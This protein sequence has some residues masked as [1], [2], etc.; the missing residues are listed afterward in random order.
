MP[1]DRFPGKKSATYGMHNVMCNTRHGRSQDI[2]KWGKTACN[3]SLREQFF[4]TFGHFRLVDVSV[5]GT[6]E[7]FFTWSAYRYVVVIFKHQEE[8]IPQA[9][10]SLLASVTPAEQSAVTMMSVTKWSAVCIFVELHDG[11]FFSDG[12]ISWVD[13]DHT[14]SRDNLTPESTWITRSSWTS[15]KGDIIKEKFALFNTRF[16]LSLSSTNFINQHW[17]LSG[18]AI[19]NGFSWSRPSD[20]VRISNQKMWAGFCSPRR[21]SYLRSC[22][23]TKQAVSSSVCIVERWFSQFYHWYTFISFNQVRHT[24]H[25]HSRTCAS[26]LST[27]WL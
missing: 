14:S 23:I 4:G 15:G 3:D 8:K 11:C 18:K 5:E 2:F 22:P 13:G 26:P 27:Q 6:C 25:A 16:W 20:Q 9:V 7:I 21:W 19:Q 1:C 10:P 12:T 17:Y 24:S